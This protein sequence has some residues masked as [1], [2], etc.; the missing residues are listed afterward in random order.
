MKYILAFFIHLS[1]SS[2]AQVVPVPLNYTVLDSAAGDL[3]CDQVDELVVAYNIWQEIDPNENIPRELIIYKKENESWKP[4]KSSLQ[5]LYG[6]RDGG[7]MGDPFGEIKIADGDVHISQ[8]GG[9]SWKWS[10]K[11]VYRFQNNEFYLVG[12]TSNFGKPCEYWMNVVF[13]LSTG[14]LNVKK[15]FEKC[16]TSDQEIYKRENETFYE[17]NLKITLQNRNEKEIK[18]ISS[19]FKHEIYIA[20]GK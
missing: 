4:W 11:D 1:L 8:S 20:N 15:E 12:Y 3:D 13:D 6:S 5:A 9:S 16:D 14:N 7:M 18:I 10:H 19:R 17:R 2:V